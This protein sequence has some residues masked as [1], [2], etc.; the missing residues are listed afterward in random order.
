[1]DDLNNLILANQK[2]TKM[3]DNTTTHAG[4][5]T[6]WLTATDGNTYLVRRELIEEFRVP[7]EHKEDVQ[8]FMESDVEGYGEANFLLQGVLQHMGTKEGMKSYDS[9]FDL[10]GDHDIDWADYEVAKKAW[11]EQYGKKVPPGSGTSDDA[12]KW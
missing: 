4:N 5:E 9:T 3:D 11:Y 6:L 8:S 7:D 10:D 2:E 1:M 12:V